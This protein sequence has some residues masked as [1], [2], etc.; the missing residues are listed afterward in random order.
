MSSQWQTEASTMQLSQRTGHLWG[1]ELELELR[2]GWAKARIGARDLGLGLAF[3]HQNLQLFAMSAWTCSPKCSLDDVNQSRH[4]PTQRLYKGLD[5][6]GTWAHS[7]S[8]VGLCLLWALFVE[9]LRK[10]YTSRELAVYLLKGFISVWLGF[11]FFNA[12]S[13]TLFRTD[14]CDVLGLG[15]V[16]MET[17]GTRG[18][19]HSSS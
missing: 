13:V 5:T 18:S 16:C 1:P 10:T 3:G 4:G 14:M 19:L 6:L 11:F 15:H 12:I 9:L 8:I 2:W 7:V 17:L